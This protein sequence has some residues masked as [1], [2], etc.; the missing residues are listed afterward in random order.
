MKHFFAIF[1]SVLL[2]LS[3]AVKAQYGLPYDNKYEY[4]GV[5]L[6]AIEN[7]DWPRQ[8]AKD[9]AGAERQKRELVAIL[10]SLKLL[11]VNTV[12]LQVRVRGDV[13][14]PS[15]IE[16][17]SYVFTGT[18]GKSPGYDPLAFAVEECH[19]RG[20][21]LHAWMVTLPLGKDAHVRKQGKLA[22]PQRMRSLCTH[23]KGQWYMEPGNPA[24]QEYI[25]ELVKEVVS[26]YDVDGIHLDYVR[27]PDRTNGYPDAALYRKHGGGL[28][29]ADWRRSCITSLVR[30]VYDGVKKL[31][32][33]VRVSCAPLGKYDDLARYSS[34]GWNA[35]DAVF[36]DAQGWM[37]DGIM[38]ILFPML[39]F[40]GNNFYPFVID[41]QENAHGR[42][43][44][45]GIGVYRLLPEYGGWPRRE[46]ERQL[47][48]SR[49]AGTAGSIMFRTAHLAGNA[50]GAVDVYSSVYRTPALVPPMEWAQGGAPSAPEGVR[51]E[52]SGRSVAISWNAVKGNSG[53]P[54][55]KY[56]VYL[57]Y[58]GC[59]DAGKAGNLIAWSL[60]GTSCEWECSAARAVSVAVT[61]VDAY[62][63]ESAPAVVSSGCDRYFADEITLPE[64]GLRGMRIEVADMYG[65]CIYRGKYS[66]RIGVRGLPSGIY[67]LKMYDRRGA[68]VQGLDFRK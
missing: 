63:R 41:W 34:L 68:F 20:M 13:I 7:L 39:Y 14:Y 53:E 35:Y 6:T 44:V 38:D 36:Q 67:F 52:R 43:I 9:A 48:T 55:V 59:V 54:A 17:F 57:S 32:P 46:I 18:A 23:Y 8:V 56:N 29:L 61:A 66:S 12:L 62:G 49:T 50:G 16:P 64:T 33:W 15:E 47:R 31:K 58:G 21:Q 19:K 22:L 51:I 27:Y 10:D 45:P 5:W 40:K 11:H 37:R 65:R 24:T 30:A 2:L 25:V 26:K 42:H 1:V 60:A 4:R 3:G 28:S